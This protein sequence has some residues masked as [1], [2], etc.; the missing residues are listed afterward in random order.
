VSLPLAA[1]DDRV[2]LR[3]LLGQ[4]G[5][6][7]V[8]AAWDGA[9]QRA[10]AVKFVH[11]SGPREA[12]RLLLEARLQARVE[13][14]HVVRVFEVGSLGGRPCVLLQLVPGQTLEAVA[15]SLPLAD[16]VELV[17]QA[18]TGLHAAHQQGLVHRD[19]KPGN[20]LVELVEEG[21]RVAYVTDFGLAHAEEGGLTRSGL[22][23]G[24]LDFMAPEQLA[25][26]GP[27]EF[28]SDI[29]SLGATLYAVLAGRPP[30][31]IPSAALEASGEGQVR[32]L[33]RILDEEPPPLDQVAPGT[34]RELAVIAAKAMEKE[35]AARYASAQAFADDLGRFQRGEPLRARPVTAGARLGR[36]IRQN[37]T[38]S[39]AIA[40]ALAVLLVAGAFALWQSRQASLEA[41]EAARLG[42]QASA[43]EGRLRM[44]YLL[45]PHDLRPTM[46]AVR[47][48]VEALR[49]LA[50]GSR[51][52]PASF[53]LG[54]GL[55]LLGGLDEARTAYERA[56]ALGFRTPT[57]A[58][59]LGSVLGRLYQRE[60]AL[61]ARTLAPGARA[62]RVAV[63]SA[64]LQ[65]PA[66][67]YLEQGDAT[68]WR[69]AMLQAQIELLQG[70]FPGARDRAA[71]ALALDP[72]RYEARILEGETWLQEARLQ[73]S[74]DHLDQ[75]AAAVEHAVP[76]LE[77]GIA[78]GRSD[79]RALRLL[80]DALGQRAN[81]QIS[82]G[83]DPAAARKR[84]L[85]AYA[86][87]AVLD[88]DDPALLLGRG[89]LLKNLARHDA[90]KGLRSA[91]ELAE[92]A[93][94]LLRRAAA[95]APK[96]PEPLMELA[97][98]LYF[99]SLLVR[100]WT[101]ATAEKDAAESAAAAAAALALAPGRADVV[102][103]RAIALYALALDRQARGQD[104]RPALEE[105]EARCREA[106]QLDPG[107]AASL[108]EVLIQ[109]LVARGK[110]D[111]QRGADPRPA[112]E[113]G[114]ALAER[115]LAD[116]SGRRT[117]TSQAGSVYT[118]AA[119]TLLEMGQDPAQQL[120][121][122]LA[123]A[124]DDLVQ[125]PELP[126]IR[127]LKAQ[128][129]AVEARR[130]ALAGLDPTAP[131]AEARQ[132]IASASAKAAVL[133]NFSQTLGW[134]A[135]SEAL[136]LADGH[137]DPA[138]ALDRC[139][140]AYRTVA[141]EAA[142]SGEGPRGLATCTLVRAA[143]MAKR[144]PPAAAAVARLGLAHALRAA[145]LDPRDPVT[146][147]LRARLQ[148]LTG[149]REGAR[150]TLAAAYAAQP[151]LRGARDARA[152][153]AELAR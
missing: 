49:P 152:A 9:L 45:P 10:V 84:A 82:A 116:A 121:R 78:T 131:L 28:R 147:L 5:M 91:L 133:S 105:L 146:L 151:L 136:W 63:L 94:Q 41:L 128:V 90:V 76:A 108:R 66:R 127:Y 100:E 1:L 34:P 102:R 12:E 145:E 119:I 149:D 107:V 123:L 103:A 37:R 55:E 98:T 104:A 112:F 31:R 13:H 14:A 124:S 23:T 79:V 33:R 25:G 74:Q 132:L 56:W 67:R 61:A 113:R 101:G 59:G 51:G 125:H 139:E 27:V 16:R 29:Y 81:F 111:W 89:R 2:E 50:A 77:A 144:S 35:P 3:E 96:D 75:A 69:G 97:L 65:E 64:T 8:H 20:V 39:R 53:A 115:M 43:L 58:E 73:S 4:G 153:E 83:K 30:F 140:R 118:W 11:G 36:W 57:V 48:E 150:S 137:G 6:G 126:V 22:L 46:K 32:L 18:A 47:A 148:G 122:A 99:R 21:R 95:A 71:E 109:G 85:Q 80:A 60:Y 70:D 7:E 26:G 120:K 117:A 44:E 135:L 114:A 88:P 110:E 86:E 17:R 54:K 15:G 141:A 138:A 40:A 62:E 87:A 42:A 130:L 142:T 19:V 24:T 72:G 134:L 106:E 38:A 143:W 93:S 129:L 68:G 92:E 52:G